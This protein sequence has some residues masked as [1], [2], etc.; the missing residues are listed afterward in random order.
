MS[1]DNFRETRDP[2]R[3][4]Q[5]DERASRL[6]PS[7]DDLASGP[8]HATADPSNGPATSQ[9]Q[10]VDTI[11]DTEDPPA[12]DGSYALPQYDQ[13]MAM[14]RLAMRRNAV[15]PVQPHQEV[16]PAQ[17]PGASVHAV[18]ANTL[19]SAYLDLQ[20]PVRRAQTTIR[21]MQE[22]IPANDPTS[23]ELEEISVAVRAVYDEAYIRHLNSSGLYDQIVGL[24]YR[25][26]LT[27]QVSVGQEY[28]RTNLVSPR[29]IVMRRTLRTC[30]N[31]IERL[32]QQHALAGDMRGFVARQAMR[33]ELLRHRLRHDRRAAIDA[34]ETLS[35]MGNST[36]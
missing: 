24:E 15:A 4:H 23:R 20:E 26:S 12:Y 11:S 3:S 30:E 2:P 1:A 33:I 36:G 22:W 28:T 7:Y 14:D 31:E 29:A 34:A 13:L 10:S 5:S 25:L 8:D 21:S 32:S 18:V 19:E 27:G 17:R 6:L 9:N 35:D 16:G